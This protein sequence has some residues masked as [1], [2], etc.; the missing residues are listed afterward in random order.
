M[1]HEEQALIEVIKTA[2]TKMDR[3]FTDLSRLEFDKISKEL[4]EKLEKQKIQERP[5][6][7]EF[8]HQLRISRNTKFRQNT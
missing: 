8:Y 5:F 4:R 1:N 3:K 2:L 7:Y 6:A